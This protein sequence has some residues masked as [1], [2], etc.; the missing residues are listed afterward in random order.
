MDGTGVWNCHFAGWRRG[1]LIVDYLGDKTC[2]QILHTRIQRLSGDGGSGAE[3]SPR[4]RRGLLPR[5]EA[6]RHQRALPPWYECPYIPYGDG[7]A[8]V[9]CRGVIYHPQR[10]LDHRGRCCNHQESTLQGR[11]PVGRRSQYQF[12]GS[13]RHTAGRGHC[14]QACGGRTDGHGIALPVT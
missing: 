5:G 6:L 14:V 7:E 8:A 1:R 2:R 10:C 11:Y 4:Q 13:R 3:C 9:A 12:G